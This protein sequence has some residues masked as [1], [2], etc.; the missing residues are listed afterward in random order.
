M[1][2]DVRDARV[3]HG[4][5]SEGYVEDVVGVVRLAVQPARARADMQQL[6]GHDVVRV[7][8]RARE[9]LESAPR[10]RVAGRGRAS[11]AATG[12]ALPAACTA[13]AA[14]AAAHRGA[15]HSQCSSL[16]AASARAASP[17]RCA[18]TGGTSRV[19]LVEEQQAKWAFS[20]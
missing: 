10:E 9:H 6:Y 18:R 20:V 15:L 2:E 1:L 16:A 11:G 19:D 5:G 12:D 8:R 17:P 13:A 14:V 4:C 3:V 7:H